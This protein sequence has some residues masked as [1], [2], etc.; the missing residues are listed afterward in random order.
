VAAVGPDGGNVLAIVLG[1]FMGIC[2]LFALMYVELSVA[3]LFYDAQLI[4]IAEATTAEGIG[5]ERLPSTVNMYEGH[6]H[7]KPLH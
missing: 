7:R 1:T 5:R 4:Q 6:D 2:L 3:K